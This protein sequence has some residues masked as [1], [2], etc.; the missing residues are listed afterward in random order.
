M[1][2]KT[3]CMVFFLL[4]GLLVVAARGESDAGTGQAL[5][6]VSYVESSAGLN[7]PQLESGRTELELGDVNADGHLDIVSIGDHG[8]PFINSGQHGVMVWFGDGQGSWSVF[9][10]GD[11][12]YGGVAL[13]DVNNDGHMDVGYGM[14]HNYADTD[15]GDQ[16][17]EV[18]LGDG[19]GQNWTPWDDGLATNGETYGMFGTDFAD[20]DNDGDLDLASISFGCCAGLHVYLNQGNGAWAQSFGF[21]G[22]NANMDL[23]FGDVNGDGLA[24]LA[25]GSQNGTV[26]L[27]DG[28]G[29]FALADGNLPPGGALGRYGLDL[30]DVNGDGRDDLSF[31]NSS[32]GIEVWRWAAAGVW[33]ELSG[34]LPAAA[35]CEATQLQDMNGDGMGDVIAAGASHV[36]VWLG[37]NSGGWTPAASFTTPQPGYI[38]AF[39]VGGDADHNGLPDIA[40]VSEEG[41]WPNERNHLRFYKEASLPAALSIAPVSPRGGETFY[42]G[43]ARLLDWVSGVPGQAA[44]TVT[45]ELSLTGPAGPWLPLADNLPNNGRYQWLLPPDLPATSAAHLRYTATTDAGS[46]SSITP[47]PFTIVGEPVQETV[48]V[49]GIWLAGRPLADGHLALSFVRLQDQAGSPVAGAVIHAALTT[50]TGQTR[51]KQAVTAENGF[52]WFYI[53]SATGGT[54]TTCVENVVHPDYVYAPDQNNE[55]CDDLVYP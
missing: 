19:T 1:K 35:W 6:T 12:G 47:A 20:V 24:D 9:Q 52:A 38:E 30:G 2:R 34:N 23:V 21:V 14:H 37:D 13:G 26:Y 42:A 40:L 41:N 28:A 32:G 7:V 36:V 5:P 49:S 16:L 15:F 31:C 50:P 11:F 33:Q 51:Q 29:G 4:C 18:A 8:S 17:I 44:S 45:I 55:T 25:A 54:W 3:V 22:G 46:A 10:N 27:G 53:W 48:H 43:S 39:R